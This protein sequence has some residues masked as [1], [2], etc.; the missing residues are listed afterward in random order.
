[1]I[2]SS[3]SK[4]PYKITLTYSISTVGDSATDNEVLL[5]TT[6]AAAF[7][8]ILS[9]VFPLLISLKTSP[10][11]HDGHNTWLVLN[12]IE[13][14]D[15]DALEMTMRAVYYD[16][17]T[18]LA[19]FFD[20]L[21]KSRNMS[22]SVE[23]RQSAI[24]ADLITDAVDPECPPCEVASTAKTIWD[25]GSWGWSAVGGL[26]SG[27]TVVAGAADTGDNGSP[28][29]NKNVPAQI[30][31]T[32]PENGF[33]QDTPVSPSPP[34]TT[35]STCTED[36]PTPLQFGPQH[37]GRPCKVSCVHCIFSLKSSSDTTADG[38]YVGMD[39]GKLQYTGTLVFKCTEAG[40]G[41]YNLTLI[42]QRNPLGAVTIKDDCD[43]PTDSYGHEIDLDV[44]L[45]GEY[46]LS[47]I[48]AI[49]FDFSIAAS[50]IAI[51]AGTPTPTGDNSSIF[52]IDNVKGYHEGALQIRAGGPGEGCHHLEQRHGCGIR[53]QRP[54]RHR[55]RG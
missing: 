6:T 26:I 21:T 38:A 33:N 8:T 34:S 10:I 18:A 15:E 5:K 46:A 40:E 55:Y 37:D 36:G 2:K 44:S 30:T 43:I 47:G 48:G 17:D 22:Y 29:V 51:Q 41:T 39:I 28:D 25:I 1:M 52:E 31:P 3:A 24:V 54:S 16:T 49:Q 9:A 42:N 35:P 7:H 12:A 13:K 4:I 23:K 53:H 50:P 32:E 45:A 14:K 19:S 27:G 20:S 11:S